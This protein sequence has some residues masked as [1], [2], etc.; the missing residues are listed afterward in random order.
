MKLIEKNYY[1]N[2]SAKDGYR[3]YLQAYASH[4]QREIF[5]VN[6]LDLG[7]IAK[8][9]GLAVPPRVDLAVKVSGGTVRKHKLKD[10]MG[11]KHAEK[12][13]FYN[14]KKDNFDRS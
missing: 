12:A 2:C 8:S 4:H 1:L 9:F 5:D 11:H 7:N 3:S 14:Q 6:Q 13:K 10:Q